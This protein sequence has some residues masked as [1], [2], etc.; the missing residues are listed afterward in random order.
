MWFSTVSKS[1][2]RTTR[3]PFGE[4]ARR[5]GYS[6]VPYLPA[7]TGRIVGSIDRTERFLWDY[8]RV[9]ADLWKENYFDH[10]NVLSDRNGLEFIGQPY[11][12]G[13]FD[14][15]SA[16]TGM[17]DPSTEFWVG[18][19]R[20]ELRHAL[21]T[22]AAHLSGRPL[23]FSESFTAHEEDGS[24]K[25][26]PGSLKALGDLGF[27][28]GVNAIIF[29]TYAHQP[30]ADARPGMTMGPY[31]IHFNRG[32]TWWE[33][34]GPWMDYLARC[35]YLLRQGR[36]CVDV[37]EFSGENSPVYGGPLLNCPGY[38]VDFIDRNYLPS[39]IVDDGDLTTASGMR[40]RILVLPSEPRG[41]SLPVLRAMRRLVHDGATV[42]GAKP[43]GTPSL[44]GYPASEQEAKLIA[45]QVWGQ[46][47]GLPGKA[48]PYGLGRV[49]ADRSALSVLTDD[50]GV[51]PDC[52]SDRGAPRTGDFSYIHRIDRQADYYFISNQSKAPMDRAF[53]F[54]VTGRQPEL[55]NP[56]DG[57]IANALRFQSGPKQT[58]VRLSLPVAGSM[59]VVFRRPLLPSAAGQPTD[60][61]TQP[62][63]SGKAQELSGPW[64]VTFQEKGGP[65]S[66]VPFE[67]LV[68]W[69]DFPDP[70]VRY[71]SGTA[72]YETTFTF[73]SETA[74]SEPATKVRLDLG[75]VEVLAR[76]ELNGHDLGIL[77]T[78]PFQCDLTPALVLG[79]NT[80]RIRITNLWPNRLIGDQRLG[81]PRHWS[82]AGAPLEWP[83]VLQADEWPAS[84]KG[85]HWMTWR[86]FEKD[87]PLL[88]SGLLGPVQLLIEP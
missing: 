77:W 10:L 27:C 58:T 49:F 55:W 78:Q 20:N 21:V 62:V 80:L 22:S 84:S 3:R 1:E 74:G 23:V 47:P 75:R 29:H 36:T 87:D 51:I 81:D 76:V 38:H 60:L 61:A 71:F 67:K 64:N 72:V 7:L 85:L 79:R 56:M 11:G 68:S 14:A 69:P 4:F 46:D 8:R 53:R 24:W 45:D 83:A 15:L 30:W 59:F 39:L 18:Q 41:L 40:Y 35:Q 88:P 37:T 31:G 17:D 6:L 44:Q 50:L 57:S 82:A 32:N 42:I 33:S 5:C 66:T 65:A 70:V 54:R 12:N 86:H 73:P 9:V 43:S 25:N 2:R 48:H 26:S 13:N 19:P 34:I 52:T 63:S 28:D 16:G